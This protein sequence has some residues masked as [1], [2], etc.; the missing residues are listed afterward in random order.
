MT[1]GTPTAIRHRPPFAL[2]PA[3]Y[4]VSL[5]IACAAG[6]FVA[7]WY[8]KPT[9]NASNGSSQ[10]ARKSAMGESESVEPRGSNLVSVPED[11][12]SASGIAIAPV[13][14][15]AF[16]T[17]LRLTGKVSL[18]EDRIAHMYPIVEGLVDEVMFTLGQTVK[19][20]DLL[21]VIHS[22]DVGRA[23]LELYQA[24]LQLEMAQVKEQLQQEITSNA[25]ELLTALRAGASIAEIELQF[26]LRGMG[27]YRERLLLAYSNYLKSQSDLERL[28]TVADSGVI[29]SKQLSSARSARNA[30]QATFQAR[31][32]QIEYE[33]TTALLLSSQALKEAETRVA[34]AATNL[35]ILG[36]SPEDIESIDPVSQGEAISHY[37]IRAPFEGTVITKDIVLR[38]QVNPDR[39]ILSIADLSSV[40]VTA[41]VYESNIPILRQLNNTTIEIHSDA[42]PDR[43]FQAKVFY[44]GEIIQETSRTIAMR[45]VAENPE[46]L[47]K[48]GMFVTI[49]LPS[50]DSR[51]A[52]LVTN[53]AVQEHQGISFVFVHQGGEAFE[54]RDIIVGESN[55]DSTVVVSGL[56]PGEAVAVQ[57]GFV[58][59]SKLLA[60]LMGEE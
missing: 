7:R 9:P 28:E 29:S 11:R 58:L 50:V 20:D 13:A 45:A 15:G 48:P 39:Q 51:E 55:A 36:C 23:K 6:F 35:R 33:L 2:R 57:G 16:Q 22:R 52:L 19:T 4:V 1:D 30:D 8:F 32:E 17:S 10:V 44:A 34:V 26:R 31:L 46:H 37:P 54:R 41:D 38:E 42:W 25:R 47:L 59:K 27:D 40:W 49:E 43:T 53:S 5:L 14:M 60:D 3:A 21:V 24:R 18:N 12:W 56:S